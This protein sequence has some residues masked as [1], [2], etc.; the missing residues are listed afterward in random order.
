L[1]YRTRIAIRMSCA[2]EDCFHATEGSEV[3][4]FIFSVDVRC[5]KLKGLRFTP[6]PCSTI[7]PERRNG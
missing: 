2:H 5:R 6:E 7:N 3:C 1:R 4:D